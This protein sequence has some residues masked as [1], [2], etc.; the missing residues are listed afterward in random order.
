MPDQDDFGVRFWCQATETRYFLFL[1]LSE[2]SS[3]SIPNYRCLAPW[4]WFVFSKISGRMQCEEPTELTN[5]SEK[6]RFQLIAV[7]ID[8]K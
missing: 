6:C 7:R 2:F 1:P 5:F 4:F 3:I 8:I